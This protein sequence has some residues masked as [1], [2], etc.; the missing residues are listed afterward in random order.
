MKVQKFENDPLLGGVDGIVSLHPQGDVAV[1]CG[2]RSRTTKRRGNQRDISK[3]RTPKTNLNVNTPTTSSLTPTFPFFGSIWNLSFRDSR[4]A[5]ICLFFAL[6]TT[7][8]MPPPTK[9]KE[10]LPWCVLWGSMGCDNRGG[11]GA[12]F[13]EE[14]SLAS[15]V[16]LGREMLRFC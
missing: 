4:A 9:G 14:I 16:I 6:R 5:C 12:Y 15:K 13:Y 2:N 11:F 3:T 10:E 1:Y 8:S 7:S